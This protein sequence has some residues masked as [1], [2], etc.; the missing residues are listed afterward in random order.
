VIDRLEKR[1]ALTRVGVGDGV[2]YSALPPSDMLSRLSSGIDAHLAGA[3]DALSRMEDRP[4][5][6]Y[7]W[8]LEGYDNVVSRAEEVARGARERLLLGVW[9][10]ESARL[11]DAVAAAQSQGV[12]VV[13][14]CVQGC[15]S[16]CGNCRGEVY[17]YP[18]T[19]EADTRWLMVVADEEQTVMGEVSATGDARAAH[20]SMP[21]IVAVAAQYI[22]NTIASAEIV[23]S[24]GP[25]LP[26]LL[27]RGSKDAL[28]GEGLRTN[29][30]S[31]FKQLLATVRRT[32]G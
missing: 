17:R 2:K 8:N 5:E 15:A 13:T 32:H 24:L 3:Q 26:R 16:E 19:K 20:T 29:G 31:W 1:G 30:Q 9:S 22:R 14:L 11:T 25:R 10:N 23:R 12:D 4:A 7:V 18:V 28:E 6:R 21:M 27:D